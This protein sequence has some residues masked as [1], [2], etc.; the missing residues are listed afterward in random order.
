MARVCGSCAGACPDGARFCPSCAAPLDERP[1]ARL[2][3][4][5][6]TA[7]FAD[8]VGSTALAE[9]EDPEIVQSVIGRAF[10]RAAHEVARHGGLVEKF[11]GDAV[12]AV[13]GVP[14]VHEDDPERAVRAALAV[15][16][17][18]ATLNRRFAEEGK[19]ALAI[20]TGVETGEVLVDLD[21]A[22]GPRHRMLTGDTVNT[23]ARLQQTAEPGQIVVG[24]VAH[25]ATKDQ[26]EY[27]ALPPRVL[28]GKAEPTP[29]WEAVRPKIAPRGERAPLRLRARMVGRDADLR[30]L[31]RIF[32]QVRSGGC[33]ALVTVLGPAGIGK[34]RLT[35]EFV[36]SLQAR[37]ERI[38]IRKGRCLS[39][40]NVS[41]SAFAEAIRAACGVLDDDPPHE[42]ARKASTTIE[43]LFG[44][45]ELVPHLEALIGPGGND[46]FG[47]E[48]LFDAW[49]RLLERMA[50]RS[51]TSTSTR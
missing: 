33:P 39:Y 4:K 14:T 24:P 35:F 47:R 15:R 51:P 23:A 29:A 16:D 44:D 46:R 20:R 34:S 28:K 48:D 42:V 49:R 19:P 13:F 38:D 6:A 9:R 30:E 7:M 17:A 8:L 1:Q 27:V 12:L 5:L 45:H 2:E 40:G 50:D 32:E 25:E 10:D 11:I 37:P 22:A 36:R 41:Y 26:I 21:R 31:E 43:G 18:F 3:R